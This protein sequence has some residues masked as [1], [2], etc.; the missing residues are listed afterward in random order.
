MVGEASV[1]K[2]RFTTAD[3]TQADSRGRPTAFELHVVNTQC[4][5][6]EQHLRVLCDM[7]VTN[8]ERY[9]SVAAEVHVAAPVSCYDRPYIKGTAT[10]NEPEAI[11]AVFEG[12]VRDLVAVLESCDAAV[13]D[14]VDGTSS[15]RCT[16]QVC[17]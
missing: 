16:T 9:R 6:D 1:M 10:A 8:P 11:V 12:A 2:A 14:D 15:G 5:C 7:V 13:Q 17:C 3:Q 4:L